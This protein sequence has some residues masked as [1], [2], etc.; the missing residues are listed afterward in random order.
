MGRKCVVKG[1]RTG[2]GG[3]RNIPFFTCRNKDLLSAWEKAIPR[4]DFTQVTP[5]PLTT[6]SPVC[7]RHFQTYDIRTHSVVKLKDGR[8]HLIKLTVPELSRV[9]V[10]SKFGEDAVYEPPTVPVPQTPSPST[11][12]LVS[13]TPHIPVRPGPLPAPP[14]PSPFKVPVRPSILVSRARTSPGRPGPSLVSG[15]V[16]STPGR[17]GPSLVSGAVAS[18][19]VRPGPSLVSGAVASTSGLVSPARTPLAASSPANS[20]NMS[21]SPVTPTFSPKDISQSPQAMD[22]TT[23]NVTEVDESEKENIVTPHTKPKKV[24][25]RQLALAPPTPE[26]SADNALHYSFTHTR[27]KHIQLPGNFWGVHTDNEKKTMFTKVDVYNR[28]VEKSLTFTEG[29]HPKVFVNKTQINMLIP[30]IKTDSDVHNAL[31]QLH[32]M[33]ACVGFTDEEMRDREWAKGCLGH[34]PFQATNKTIRCFKCLVARRLMKRHEDRKTAQDK[35]KEMRAKVKVHAKAATRLIKKVDSLKAEMSDLMKKLN[36]TNASKLDDIIK[37]LPEEQR[38]LV[39]TCFDAAKHHNSKNRRYTTDWIYDCVLMRV[40][41]P[42]LYEQL[43]TKNKLALPSQRTL[44]RYMRALRPAFGFQ[45]NVFTLLE[46]KSQQYQIGERHGSI[47]LD[48]IALEARTYFDKNTCKVHGLVD[49]GGFEEESDKDKRGD[50]ALVVMF[51]P[52]K[53]K[54]VQALGAFLSCGAVNSGKLHKI[55]LEAICLLEKSG[56]FVDCV[57]TDAATWNRS[58]WDLFGINHQSPA[59]EHPLDPEREL[60]FVSDFPHLIKSLWT[61]ILDRKELKLPEGTIN[62]KH[63]KTL[64]KLEEEKG[65]KAAF[66]LSK[67]HVDPTNYQKMKVRLAMQFF[68]GRVADAMQHYKELGVKELEDAGPTIQF[69]RRI[70]EVVDAM[71]SQLPYQGLQPDPNSTHHKNLL[72][73]LS[74]LDVMNEM[75]KKKYEATLTLGAKKRA[76]QKPWKPY[77]K[78]QDEITTSAWLGLVVTIKNALNLVNY[79]SEECYYL[80]LMTRRLN[81]DSLEHFFGH[82][83]GACGANQ[84][85]DPRMFVNV[86]RL[87]MTYSLVKPPRGSNVFGGEVMDALLSLKDLKREEDEK[88]SQEVE[89]RID[90]LLE[91]DITVPEEMEL[92]TANEALATSSVDPYA[93]TVFGGYVVRKVRQIAPTKDC[94]ECKGC[95]LEEG[96]SQP[97]EALLSI[98]T[99]GGLL[100]PS[101]RLFDLLNK[102]EQAVVTVAAGCGVHGTLIFTVLDEL[103]S[104]TGGIQMIGCETHQR[105]LTTSIVSFFLNTRL[106]FVCAQADR[107]IAE[108]R[109]QKRNMAKIAKLAN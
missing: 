80:Y 16:A 59:C 61:R 27:A 92:A 66:S 26:T 46:T 105:G 6:S 50:H 15:A 73:F 70:N 47:L 53:G 3:D 43:R 14:A 108:K 52:F 19:P 13:P 78:Y 76:T 22:I 89:Q 98:R 104:S 81:Q 25:R 60:R 10:P 100:R 97:R 82:I 33:R 103:L 94:E 109:K 45:E 11:S 20:V 85:P 12:S 55:I 21:I 24:V 7:G 77:V 31:K 35:L 75:A 95:L 2:Y 48:E 87:L 32:E 106:H 17:P 107:T 74:Y 39:Q 57:V 69:I 28:R 49:L 5:P 86:Y 56:Y 71:N 64:L 101:Q 79:L 36:K 44:L 40:K 65:I 88:R 38:V 83:R 58:M 18:T 99:R 30:R 9:A 91:C 63:W 62:L 102:L 84:H 4:R 41:A 90:E 67:D 72:Q 96:D 37:I 68:G 93:L 42:G 23:P 54:W 8:V 51:Q 34:V 29:Q 1:C